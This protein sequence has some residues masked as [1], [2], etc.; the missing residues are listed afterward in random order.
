MR[1]P[2]ESHRSALILP[3]FLSLHSTVVPSAPFQ[4]PDTT[5]PF[6]AP[7][8]IQNNI[9]ADTASS[10]RPQGSLPYESCPSAASQPTHIARRDS[11]VDNKAGPTPP[12]FQPRSQPPSVPLARNFPARRDGKLRL[13]G[14]V[15]PPLPQLPAARFRVEGWCLEESAIIFGP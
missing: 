8:S 6:P 10:C 2:D 12:Q 13:D 14:Q 4:V 3:F 1:N 11:R 9:E 5:M 15:V 7:A